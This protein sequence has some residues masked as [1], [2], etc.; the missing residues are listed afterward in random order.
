[1][2]QQQGYIQQPSAQV[3]CSSSFFPHRSLSLKVIFNFKDLIL[4]S[5]GENL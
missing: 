4:N 5:L 2:L 3:C 1:V